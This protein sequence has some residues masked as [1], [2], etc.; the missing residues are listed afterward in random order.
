MGWVI[1]MAG[2]PGSG[3]STI[4]AALG[5][6]YRI[7]VLDVDV[8]KSSLLEAGIAIADVGPVAYR[9]LRDLAPAMA[10]QSGSVILDSPCHHPEVLQAGQRL[11]EAVGSLFVVIECWSDDLELLDRRI[12]TR[13]ALRSQRRSVAD[14]PVDL[15][16]APDPRATFE[17]WMT[18]SVLPETGHLRVDA[19]QPPEVSLRAVDEFLARLGVAEEQ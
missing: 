8:I 15:P 3:K 7:P 19:H 5:A 16:E 2:P 14:G 18:G 11:G 10:E 9:V 12:R 4:A 6:R 17:G 1:Q 13:R